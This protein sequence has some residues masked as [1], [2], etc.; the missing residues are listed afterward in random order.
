MS[1]GKVD[2]KREFTRMFLKKQFRVFALSRE[3]EKKVGN[4]YLI[5]LI[6]NSDRLRFSFLYFFYCEKTNEHF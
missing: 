3:R 4:S 1:E 2:E 5:E 6:S